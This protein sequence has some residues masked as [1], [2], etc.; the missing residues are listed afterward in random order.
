M[1]P[2]ERLTAELYRRG[3]EG[4][5]GDEH[6]HLEQHRQT[7]CKRTCA[8]AA[9]ESHGLLLALHGV[10]LV[11]ILVVDFLD[12]RSENTHLRLA[13]EALESEGEDDELD[14]ECQ[15]QDDDAV[16]VD[17]RSEESE[18]RYDNDGI[19]PAEQRPSQRNEARERKTVI[20]IAEN[21]V[22]T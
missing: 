10:C 13:L 4:E 2:E 20:L 19:Y 16:I 7:A 12:F 3:E 8:Y 6:R 1:R 9:V 17:E 14:E 11:G 21:L 5:H 22:E 15:K 18:Y